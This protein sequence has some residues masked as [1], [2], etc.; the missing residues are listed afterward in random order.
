LAGYRDLTAYEYAPEHAHLGML[1][2]GWLESSATYT[3]GPVPPEFADRLSELA[4]EAACRRTRGFHVC[5]LCPGELTGRVARPS[6]A[7]ERGG[8]LLLGSAEIRVVAP[9][10]KWYAAPELIV[11]Y[12]RDHGYRPPNGFVEAVLSGHPRCE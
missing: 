2:V 11:H 4:H 5:D 3:R 9:D 1:N 12:V 10:G 7:V 6:V 8:Q